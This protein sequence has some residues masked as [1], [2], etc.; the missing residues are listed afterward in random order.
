MPACGTWGR[1]GEREKTVGDLLASDMLVSPIDDVCVSVGLGELLLHLL[2]EAL[3]AVVD[4]G[5]VAEQDRA[6]EELLLGHRDQSGRGP[7]QDVIRS[8]R[9]GGKDRRYRLGDVRGPR[10]PRDGVII[11]R[12]HLVVVVVVV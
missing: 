7:G 11:V 3:D 2:L 6:D 12:R 5:H 8:A 10:D 4:D 1:E 9:L